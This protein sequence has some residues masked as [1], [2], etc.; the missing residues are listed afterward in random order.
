MLWNRFAGLIKPA[1]KS[2][3]CSRSISCSARLHVQR[4][5]WAGSVLD[6]ESSSLQEVPMD[7][8]LS[9]GVQADVEQGISFTHLASSMS[10][11]L[12]S[13]T[14]LP[15]ALPVSLHD[16]AEKDDF[17]KARVNPSGLHKVVAVGRNTFGE[18]G[19]GFSSQES[20]WG[21]VTSGF[22][23]RGGIS[24]I[25]CGLGSSWMVTGEGR[26][27]ESTSQLYAF[28]NHTSGQ[29]G[30]GGAARPHA[31]SEGGEPQL[32][33]LSS[34]RK[35]GMKDFHN[36][37][38]EK[39]AVGMDHT[40][41]LMNV[42]GVQVVATCG[43]NTDGQL[44]DPE[45]RISSP[46]LVR[47]DPNQFEP[48]LPHTSHDPIVGIS[49]GGDSSALWT[50]SG[51]IWAWGN[52]EYGQCLVGGKA[53]DRI[54]RP[55]EASVDVA[56]CTEARIVD[57]RLGGCFVVVL[58]EAGNVYTAG[59]GALGRG[60]KKI[61]SLELKKVLSNATSISTGLE[62][63]SAVVQDPQT[64]ET[65]LLVWGLNTP[66]GRLGIGGRKPWPSYMIASRFTPDDIEQRVWEPS[67]TSGWKQSW[68]GKGQ[69]GAGVKE[70]AH[71]RDV[72][73]VLVEDGKDEVG[74]WAGR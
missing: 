8:L 37:T 35:V 58:D 13:Y 59:F 45:V 43:I 62:Q 27:A 5:L 18:L 63:A 2:R 16:T 66:A 48:P 46:S 4:L 17:G 52:S 6:R 36:A 74:R 49:A 7:W 57:I 21:M 60:E 65:S 20:T 19:L 61:E 26:P 41:V 14:T 51:R 28:G 42:D 40:V 31:L 12:L 70:V 71:G 30:L 25:Q 55:T 33:L 10:H 67:A 38:V 47:L 11:S 22:E 44:G 56:R 1:V 69:R 29:L 72:M 64:K 50:S 3:H 32:Q 68:A 73:W 34:P 15:P 24:S 54:D 23:G 39:I 9:L 53:I